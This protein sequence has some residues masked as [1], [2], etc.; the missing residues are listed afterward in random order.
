M[1]LCANHD[2]LFDK[3]LITFNFYDGKI[4]ISN[5]LTDEEKRICMLNENICLEEKVLTDKTK[6][7]LMWHNEEFQKLEQDRK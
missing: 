7:Y 1:L 3:F 2:K 4:Q 5:S 6:E